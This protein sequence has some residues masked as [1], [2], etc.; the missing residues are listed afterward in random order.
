M[1][2]KEVTRL[3]S[4]DGQPGLEIADNFDRAWRRVGLALDR[5]GFTVEDRDRGQGIYFVRYVE[6]GLDKKSSNFFS[7]FFNS[8][9]A[10]AALQTAEAH[11][12]EL[13][14]AIDLQLV[15]DKERWLTSR[16]GLDRLH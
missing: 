3:G 15:S 7:R 14:G 1:P 10:T 5:S 9:D 16:G 6:A 13:I 11:R 8:S 4:F 2:P 12:T